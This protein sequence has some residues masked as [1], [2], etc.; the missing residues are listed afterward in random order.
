MTG[1]FDLIRRYFAPLATA[2]G[3]LGLTDDAALLSA[4]AGH[5]LVITIDT[6]VESVHFLAADPVDS[7]GGKL[8]GV[9]LS[10]LAAMGSE[11]LGYVL[12]VALPL[13]WPSARCEQWLSEFVRGLAEMQH[14]FRLG[15]LGG[16][17]V[18]TP[19]DVCLTATA[20]GQVPR[21][22][23]LRR[24]GASVG[25]LVFVSGSIGDAALGLRVLTA[26]LLPGVCAEAAADL[27]DRYRWPRPRVAFG[28]RLRRVV[29]A[30]ADISDGL[31]ADLGHVCR[32]SGVNAVI[33][34]TCVPMS[35]AVRRAVDASP[36]L[37]QLVL[38]GGDDYEL[39]FTAPEA[40]RPLIE[41]LAADAALPVT[42]IGTI[43][44]AGGEEWAGPVR[45]VAGEREVVTGP[46][47]FQHFSRDR[48]K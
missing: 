37:L 8:L 48:N 14:Y 20:F 38:S 1:E 34:V 35:T 24:S 39:V 47:G 19:G 21:D 32:A 28:Q 43:V 45:V 42:C 41:W 31:V 11:P 33:D 9:N 15:L 2:G 7:V 29:H 13:A 46:G 40:S 22:E 27:V 23:A 12:A 16:D 6:I 36:D 44:A 26:G 18:A 3:A 4:D 5:E 17:T 10:D 25:D 30:A